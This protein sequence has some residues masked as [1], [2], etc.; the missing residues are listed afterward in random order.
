MTDQTDQLPKVAALP[1]AGAEDDYDRILY[2]ETTEDLEAAADRLTPKA[3]RGLLVTM[4]LDEALPTE[5]R[6]EAADVYLQHVE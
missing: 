6:I 1:D 4:M 2:G 5:R 3:V